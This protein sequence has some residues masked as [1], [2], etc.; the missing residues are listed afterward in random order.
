MSDQD[1][2]NGEIAVVDVKLQGL[3]HSV[4]WYFDLSTEL[5]KALQILPASKEVESFEVRYCPQ[6]ETMDG[7]NDYDELLNWLSGE[8]A[9][10]DEDRVSRIHSAI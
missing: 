5:A 3:D 4:P 2:M 1:E 10:P 8:N 9:G 6:S 7:P